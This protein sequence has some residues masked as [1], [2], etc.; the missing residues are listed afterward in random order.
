MEYYG[1]AI[2]DAISVSQ[3]YTVLRPNLAEHFPGKGEAHPF[4]EII[5][6]TRGRHTLLIDG[7]AY[8]FSKGQ[9]II[10]APN[11][12]HESSDVCPENAEAAILTFDT[13]SEIL[14]PLYNRV[15]TLTERQ[16]RM[17]E[18]FIDEGVRC[19]CG[20]DPAL[21]MA[22]MQLREGVSEKNLWGLKK[23]IEL[24]LID[25]YETDTADD[26]PCAKNA[27][28][29]EDMECATAYLS[30]HLA[31][32][33]T[34][35]SIAEGCSVSVSKLKLLFREKVGM[36]PIEYCIRLRVERAKGLI[37]EGKMNFSQIAEAVGFSSLHYFS[38]QFKQ[39]TGMS[40]S[41]F[42]KHFS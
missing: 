14:T 25:V 39:I 10:Y 19:L 33:L 2:A 7:E 11:S 40:P 34:L 29:D 18:A 31:E 5:Y 35:A 26:A 13:E 24:F 6:L 16:R 23:Q 27:R 28:W 42:S 3:I 12:Y 22:G 4:P 1:T 21:G 15:I 30:A 32:P 36:G 17:L 9:M 20:R 38:R 37:R 41:E 8:T